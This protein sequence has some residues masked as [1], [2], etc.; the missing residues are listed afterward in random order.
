MT[1]ETVLTDK[2]I[3]KTLVD[4]GILYATQDVTAYDITIARAIQQ[5]VLQS[6]EIQALRK[7]ADRYRWLRTQCEKPI[8]G[9]T[10]C[11]VGMFDL[12]PWSGDDPDHYIDAAMETQS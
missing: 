8:G 7:D 12:K 4:A 10:I 9:L 3:S 11:E 5:A 1:T 6:P 2:E